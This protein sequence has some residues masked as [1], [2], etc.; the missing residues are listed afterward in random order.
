MREGSE[1]VQHS[2]T[3]Q[4][5][6]VI[7]GAGPAGLTAAYEL[8]RHGKS[9]TIL[10]KLS[11]PGGLARTE[12]Y[13]G[14]RFDIGGHRFFTRVG[15]VAK[16]WRDIL[17]EE[18]L[19]RPRLSRILYRKQF[20]KYPLDPM[21][22]LSR[23]GIWESV[24]CL[25][26]YV[27]AKLSRKSP[28]TGDLESWLISRFGHRLYKTFFQ[29]YTEKVWGVPC[30]SIQAEWAAQRIRGLS[31]WTLIR[32]T[33]RSL[34][35]HSANTITTLIKEF[36]YP[37]LGPGQMWRETQRYIEERGCQ[38]LLNTPVTRIRW[39]DSGVRSVLAGGV[40]YFAG[41]FLSTLAIRDFIYAL[42]PAP[43]PE[44]RAAA[45]K[46]QY[47]DFIT[48][49]LIIR[50]AEV[51]PDNWLYIHEPSVKVGRIQNYKNWSPD[52]VP[53]VAFTCLGLEYF[54]FENDDLWRASDTQLIAR[55][56]SDL[57]QLGLCAREKVEDGIVIRVPKAYPVYNSGYRDALRIL[58]DFLANRLPNLQSIGRNGMHRYNNQDHSMLTGM[59]AARNIL[60]LG[61]FNLWE[62]NADQDY[63]EDGFRL[64]EAEIQEL[65]LSQPPVPL[66]E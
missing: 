42:D 9:T 40:E 66:T 62:V 34:T 19:A 54:C 22:T 6:V 61:P 30:R 1:P 35:G 18:F 53:D 52:M 16:M 27:K 41:Q 38:V 23:L 32:E 21:E 10:E 2:D 49:A 14:F 11:M 31:L 50:Q 65:E 15:V 39:D 7:L 36:D 8:I 64:T 48:V 45:G 33:V 13:R 63:H 60:G 5:A 29:T 37:R 44:V 57:H 55:A 3:G 12:Q 47:R 59:L 20:F 4:N 56:K 46:L 26:S 51:F 17:G 43:P 58:R 25:A 24:Q 28:E